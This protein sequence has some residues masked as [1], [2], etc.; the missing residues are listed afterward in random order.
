MGIIAA[1][2]ALYPNLSVFLFF[3]P[4]GGMAGASGLPKSAKKRA[5]SGICPIQ[6]Y[7][8]TCA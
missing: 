6:K 8:L 4:R 2:I 5:K 1:V 3:L 7:A